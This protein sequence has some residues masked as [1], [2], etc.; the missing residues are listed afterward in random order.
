LN[1]GLLVLVTAVL[2]SAKPVLACPFCSAMSETLSETMAN[3]DVVVIAR[4]GK[5]PAE[6]LAPGQAVA[7]VA[8][9][10]KEVLKG[11]EFMQGTRQF[12][13]VFFGDPTQQS[14]KSFLLL[15]MDPPKLAWSAAQPLSKNAVSY[16]RQLPELPNEGTER[17]AFFHR[18]L[19]HPD[20]LLASDA[21]EEFARTSYDVVIDLKEQMDRPQLIEW[22]KDPR[23]PVNRRRLFLTMLGVCGSRQDL[24]F[25]EQ[26]M[27][28]PDRDTNSGLDALIGCYLTLAG[29][30]G[31][32]LIEQLFIKNKEAEYADTYAAIMALR[33]HGSETDVVPRDRILEAL[34]HVLERPELADLVIPDL[35]RWE[36]W[37][38]MARMVE[39][40]KE[41]EEGASWVRVPVVNYLRACPEAEAE[42]YIRELEKIDPDAVK[43]ANTFLPFGG[44]GGGRSPRGD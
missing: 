38:V 15:G 13:A 39:L 27:R 16:I 24:P 37:S 44:V 20:E 8:F 34:R 6:G 36:D 41:A 26:L 22:I 2:A 5:V 40:F 33:F 3:Q 32:P 12:E 14:D 17:L 19:E 30:E 11:Q 10:V 1:Y 4:M 7:K 21:Y 9:D 25:L 31:M 23:V 43:R 35:A 28:S 29:E 18:Y 42:K